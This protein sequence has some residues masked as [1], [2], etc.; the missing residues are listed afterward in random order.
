MLSLI[1]PSSMLSISRGAGSHNSDLKIPEL[2]P[3]LKMMKVKS[4]FQWCTNKENFI[5]VRHFGFFSLFL[6]HINK[7]LRKNMKYL[8]FRFLVNLIWATIQFSWPHFQRLLIRSWVNIICCDSFPICLVYKV[9]Y[10]YRV[11]LFMWKYLTLYKNVLSSSRKPF[12]L[13]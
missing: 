10:T 8:L 5:M 4:K 1:W 11:T 7:F 13:G 6:E 9:D 2:F 3:S 12:T